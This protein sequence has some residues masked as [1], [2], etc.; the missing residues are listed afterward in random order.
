MLATAHSPNH[1]IRPRIYENQWID[2]QNSSLNFLTI[3]TIPEEPDIFDCQ[4]SCRTDSE[5]SSS[6]TEDLYVVLEVQRPRPPN[7]PINKIEKQLSFSQII[8]DQCHVEYN[9]LVQPLLIEIPSK[10]Y[11]V[12]KIITLPLLDNVL[13]YTPKIFNKSITKSYYDSLN[14]EKR[15]YKPIEHSSASISRTT[16]EQ[17]SRNRTDSNESLDSIENNLPKISSQQTRKTT[18]FANLAS[19][20]KLNSTK[21]VQRENSIAEKTTL[22]HTF[23]FD[24]TCM[25][26]HNRV[27]NEKIYHDETVLP[28]YL[29]HTSKIDN[30]TLLSNNPTTKFPVFRLAKNRAQTIKSEYYLPDEAIKSTEPSLLQVKYLDGRATLVNNHIR[31]LLEK[32]E[33]LSSSIS[34]RMSVSKMFHTEDISLYE[35]LRKRISNRFQNILKSSS[36]GKP[37]TWQHK[38]VFELFSER[39]K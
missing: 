8:D 21:Q 32:P 19:Q 34:S 18:T 14:D 9:Q 38:T 16:P 12:E 4:K 22:T 35:S 24:R 11:A 33:N 29:N 31:E 37:K 20:R 10:E 15:N 17:Q 23:E 6:S 39:K 28:F 7:E 2:N 27:K 25:I 36:T 3:Q 5:C 13:C 1:Y 30:S 26:K